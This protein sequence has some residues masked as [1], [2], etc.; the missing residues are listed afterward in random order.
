[1]FFTLSVTVKTVNSDVPGFQRRVSAGDLRG[2]HGLGGG[3]LGVLALVLA[4]S[5]QTT[6]AAALQDGLA[7]LVELQLDDQQWV[8]LPKPLFSKL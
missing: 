7:V 4:E 2:L 1:L 8:S 3:L 5:G 6:L